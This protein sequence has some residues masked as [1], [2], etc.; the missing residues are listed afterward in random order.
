MSREEYKY[1]N[2]SILFVIMGIFVFP[3]IVTK[4]DIN[5]KN[6]KGNIHCVSCGITRDFYQI[7]TLK[8]KHSLINSHS[9]YIIFI[10]LSNLIFRLFT[11][12]ITNPNVYL[13]RIIKIDL[14]FSSFSILLL[15]MNFNIIF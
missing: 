2:W 4:Y 1:L 8:Q 15:F 10:L 14:I 9:F 11:I 7:I 12:L 13:Y 5:I 3:L 6:C